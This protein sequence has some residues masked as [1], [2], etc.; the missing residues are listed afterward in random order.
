MRVIDSDMRS[1]GAFDQALRSGKND[2]GIISRLFGHDNR[3]LTLSQVQE[4]VHAGQENYLGM[5]DLHTADVIGSED[6]G[7]DFSRGF[8]PV[9]SW[10]KIRWSRVYRLM[11]N[12][13]L[14]EAVSLIEI[15]GKYF[16]RDGHHRISVAK[17]LGTEFISAQVKSCPLPYRLPSGLDRNKLRLLAAKDRF[18]QNTGI[19][20]HIND[21]DFYVRQTGTWELLEKEI[22]VDNHSWFVRRFGREPERPEEQIN[23]WYDNCYINVLDYVRRNSL[24]YLFPGMAETDIVAQLIKT[25][26]SFDKPDEIWLG[27]MYKIFLKKQRRQKRIRSILQFLISRIRSRLMSAEDEYRVFASISRIEELVP[28]FCPLEKRKG[29]YSYLY[30][31]LI[32]GYAQVLK[33]SYKRA[34]YIHELTTDWHDNYYRPIRIAA[35]KIHPDSCSAQAEYY[36]DFS[37]RYFRAVCGDSN[38]EP[39]I[40][41]EEALREFNTSREQK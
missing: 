8:L 9:R 32:H 10:M 4:I 16:V 18:Q 34:P 3:L 23:L 21:D 17:V 27:E 35:K 2:T 33:R 28:D 12:G 15:G 11:Y 19:F 20:N 6:R 14:N 36:M 7:D 39:E 40:S 31:Q 1:S 13:E 29:V 24:G 22:L 26:N 25:W 5:Q 37:D 38:R 30:Q 41:I